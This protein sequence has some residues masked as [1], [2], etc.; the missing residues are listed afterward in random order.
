MIEYSIITDN[1]LWM[2]LTTMW[3]SGF[4]IKTDDYFPQ[5]RARAIYDI[6][7]LWGDDE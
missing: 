3:N 4:L 2:Q 1:E 5:L 6:L 7:T